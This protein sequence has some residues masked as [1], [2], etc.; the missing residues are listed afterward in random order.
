MKT[1][2]FETKNAS[3]PFLSAFS[4]RLH[5][6]VFKSVERNKDPGKGAERFLDFIWPTWDGQ[7][8][9]E[10]HI[11]I[12]QGLIRGTKAVHDVCVRDNIDWYYFDQPYFFSNDY[13]QS[14]TGDKWYRICKNNTQKNYI[15]KSKAVNTRF[16]VLMNRIPQNCRDELTPKPWQYE[17]KHILVIPPSYHTACWY[18]IDRIEWE[19]DIVKKIKQHTRKDIV[20]RQKFKDDKDWSPDR[21]E[22]PLSDDL[23]DCYAM[24]S[25]HSMCAVHAVMAGVPSFCSEHSPAYPVSLGLNE[26]DQIKDPLYTGERN[27]W[28]K[29]LMCAQF[30]LDEMQKGRAWSHLNGENKW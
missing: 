8:P 3:T 14:D 15:E 1:Y 5:P 16:E 23:K 30:T 22:T 20:V 29:S 26:L 2:Q 6:E 28:V 18:G 13:K 24:V 17:G 25:F 12:F 4:A 10:N 7:I 27:D 21:K 11:A 9:T 19:K